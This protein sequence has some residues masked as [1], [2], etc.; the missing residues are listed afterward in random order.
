RL[1]AGDEMVELAGVG[2]L[3]ARAP[4]HPQPQIGPSAD[5]A[6]DVQAIGADAEGGHGGAL[7]LEQPPAEGRSDRIGLVA[8]A[9]KPTLG[10]QRTQD[11]ADR[12]RALLIAAQL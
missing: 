12:L 10:S 4:P 6:V 5:E 9:A 8:P 11:A 2:R 7:D 1:A 3:V